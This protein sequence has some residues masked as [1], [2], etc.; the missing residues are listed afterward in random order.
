MQAQR[1]T[2]GNEINKTCKRLRRSPDPTT[3][4][5]RLCKRR[6]TIAQMTRPA[7]VCR[8]GVARFI[9][10]RLSLRSALGPIQYTPAAPVTA[11][12]CRA[13]SVLQHLQPVAPIKVC[14]FNSG[15]GTP[16]SHRVQRRHSVK[17]GNRRRQPVIII[18]KYMMTLS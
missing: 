4:V 15:T 12:Q 3:S 10:P 14:F 11:R 18:F 13:A 5:G 17:A 9:W 8:D 6:T 7:A 16:S 1:C 2:I